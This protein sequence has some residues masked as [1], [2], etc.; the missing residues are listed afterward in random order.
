MSLDSIPPAAH[1]PQPERKGGIGLFQL[2][3][4]GLLLLFLLAVLVV[5]VIG[6]VSPAS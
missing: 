1:E 6:L 4:F 3:G 5:V 2:L